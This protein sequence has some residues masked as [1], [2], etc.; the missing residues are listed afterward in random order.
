MENNFRK[1]IEDDIKLIKEQYGYI[2][3][4]INIDAYAFNY[5]VL[6]R[7]YNL[8]EEIISNNSTDIND[9]GIDCFVHYEYTK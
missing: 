1:Q 2:D 5:W 9:K 6:S 4:K 8:D 3:E 7:L